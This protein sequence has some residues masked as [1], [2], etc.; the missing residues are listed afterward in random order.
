MVVISLYVHGD[1]RVN[2]LSLYL[3]VTYVHVHSCK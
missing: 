2:Y 3:R 1:L